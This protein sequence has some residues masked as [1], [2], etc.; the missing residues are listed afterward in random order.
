MLTFAIIA[1]VAG[2]VADWL[3]TRAALAAGAHEV[4]LLRF[5]GGAWIWLR[6]VL[7]GALV[8]YVVR[9][10]ESAWWC[11]G[12]GCAFAALGAW[13]YGV[14][15]RQEEIAARA[16]GPAAGASTG[17]GRGARTGGRPR[18]TGERHGGA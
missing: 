6:W 11:V 10:P 4:G 12:V 14:A 15:R 13:N 3:G 5:A 17:A 8:A 2:S 7:A 16:A 18:S 1:I 9:W